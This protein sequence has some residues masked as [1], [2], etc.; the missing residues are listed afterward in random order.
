[1]TLHAHAEI[2]NITSYDSGKLTWSNRVA[3]AQY[4]V[5]WTTSP[6]DQW[7]TNNPVFTVSS[8]SNVTSIDIPM[9][10][11]VMW[12][13]APSIRLKTLNEGMPLSGSISFD[14][15]D[16]HTNDLTFTGELKS[17]P[18]GGLTSH[19]LYAKDAEYYPS[20]VLEGFLIDSNLQWE[21][22][23]VYLASRTNIFG[24]FAHG[25]WAGV[26]N[27]FLPFRLL[28]DAEYLYGWVHIT[29]HKT[30]TTMDPIEKPPIILT[31]HQLRLEEA[32]YET[33]PNKAVLAGQTE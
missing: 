29:E 11:R 22:S 8:T 10:Y 20:P 14:L 12:L 1:M 24:A 17:I 16:D 3:N 2:L 19:A 32:A 23:S 26:T 28:R 33:I 7:Q 30:V 5:E 18:E 13:D 6:A 25:P 4:R 27:A 15:D 21:S 9:Y 31:Q